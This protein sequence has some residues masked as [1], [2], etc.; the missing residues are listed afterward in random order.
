M[1]NPMTSITTALIEYYLKQANQA[2]YEGR[3][4]AAAGFMRLI[5]LASHIDT[6]DTKGI[7]NGKAR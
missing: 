2:Y 7:H 3:L 5:R 6:T 4:D 1:K